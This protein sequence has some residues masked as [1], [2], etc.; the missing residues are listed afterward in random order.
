MKTKTIIGF[1]KVLDTY[2]WEAPVYDYQIENISVNAKEKSITVTC[3]E[4]GPDMAM[5]NNYSLTLKTDE[6]GHPHIYN[7]DDNDVIY[8]YLE[9]NE[10]TKAGADQKTMWYTSILCMAC[11]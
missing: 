1:L 2:M 4:F 10:M 9:E 6:N 11:S 7:E 3:T 8:D 5:G